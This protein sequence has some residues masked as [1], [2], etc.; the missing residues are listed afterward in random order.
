MNQ[1]LISVDQEKRW[2]LIE[3]LD[4]NYEIVVFKNNNPFRSGVLTLRLI[5]FRI[6][7]VK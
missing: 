4:R 3:K 2:L 7:A 6:N 5:T 1:P